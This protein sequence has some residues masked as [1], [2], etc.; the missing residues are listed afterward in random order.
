[1][2]R[3]VRHRDPRSG[4]GMRA[5]QL[6]ARLLVV[7]GM[8]RRRLRRRRRDERAPTARRFT[9]HRDGA[10]LSR[11]RAR[12]C[13]CDQAA[14]RATAAGH[15]AVERRGGRL[16]ERARRERGPHRLGEPR[17]L[18]RAR[19]TALPA[20]SRD[21]GGRGGDLHPRDR[22][23]ESLPLRALDDRRGRECAPVDRTL[24]GHVFG[25]RRRANRRPTPGRCG[26]GDGVPVRGGHDGRADHPRVAQLV[27]PRGT[28]G[29]RASVAAR[30]RSR[31]RLLH[32]ADVRSAGWLDGRRP[33]D[34]QGGR[35]AEAHRTIESVWVARRRRRRSCR[36]H[37]S[38]ALAVAD[39]RVRA[40][41]AP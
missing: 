17:A 11:N 6:A 40:A 16:S 20:A 5:V 9:P 13:L 28:G 36:R 39:D 22:V 12:V 2:V 34:R 7:R 35:V 18:R 14:V 21:R 38:A 4:A 3:C 41:R 19:A 24:G 8:A 1:M 10:A 27:L 37:A 29:A 33:G 32:A 15:A 25:S 23:L 31:H 26:R 30:V